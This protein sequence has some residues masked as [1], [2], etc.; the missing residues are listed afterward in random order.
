MPPSGPRPCSWP[1]QAARPRL[2][3][4]PGAR[5][6][7]PIDGWPRSWKLK[8]SHHQLLA[9]TGPISCYRFIESQQ[10]YYPVCMLCQQRLRAAMRRWGLHALQLNSFPPRTTGSTYGIH[11]APNQLLNQLKPTQANRVRVRNSTYL[12]L[13]NGNWACLCA[14][15]DM[16]NKQVV[17]WHA[18]ATVSE[19][20]IINDLQH[21]FWAQPP[22]P[23]ML[24]HS[25]RSGQYHGNAYCKLLHDHQ[26]L[27]SQS[28][29]VDCYNNSQTESLW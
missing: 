21:A 27:C 26:A 23:N 5:C 14:F 19:E 15:Q 6:G 3:H 20:I 25:H 12:P 10:G 18:M 2:R 11:C 29:R 8:K 17:G 28:R 13:P 9:A 7:P 1:L 22:T 16:A 24:V 4:A